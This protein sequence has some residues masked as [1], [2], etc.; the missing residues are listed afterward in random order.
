VRRG[1]GHAGDALPARRAQL[2]AGPNPQPNPNPDPNP[3]PNP[4]PNLTLTL[5]L[6]LTL[7]WSQEPSGV[8]HAQVVANGQFGWLAFGHENPGGGHNGMDGQPEP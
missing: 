5:T 3:Y 7:S 6:T 1:L 2:V 8:V 4:N